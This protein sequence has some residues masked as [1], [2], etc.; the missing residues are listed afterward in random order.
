M[1]QAARRRR[2]AGRQASGAGDRDARLGRAGALGRRSCVRWAKGRPRLTSRR[3]RRRRWA[4][5]CESGKTAPRGSSGSPRTRRGRLSRRARSRRWPCSCAAGAIRRS[6][7]SYRDGA[8]SI[9]EE[10]AQVVAL[11]L[12]ASPGETVLDACAGRGNK[13]ALLA[14]LVGPS[15]AVDAADQHPSKLTRLR[16]ELQRQKLA[17]RATLCRGLDG[18]PGRCAFGLRPR[19]RRRPLLGHGHHPPSPRSGGEVGRPKAVRA[20]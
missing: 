16:A 10:G 14:E 12:G 17:A 4:C 15:G 1:L 2:P 3:R 5:A 13:T 8:L 19:A 7:R 20:P 6:C 18:G 11:A 9:H